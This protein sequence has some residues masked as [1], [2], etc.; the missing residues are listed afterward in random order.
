MKGLTP[1]NNKKVKL[2]AI[3]W[4]IFLVLSC[5][6]K[7]NSNNSTQPIPNEKKK[8]SLFIWSNYVSDEMLQLF[9]KKYNTKVVISN[10][11]SNE[12]L[13]SKLQAGATGYDVIVPS[14]YMV[15]VMIKLNLLQK[16][17]KK[18]IENSK[19]IEDRYLN[20]KFD[21]KN[22]YT[23][24]Y[25]WATSGLA[26]N[27]KYFKGKIKSW[28]NLFEMPELKGK[29]N[30]LDDSREVFGA[31]LKLDGHS[32]NSQNKD[33]LQKAK[34]YLKKHKSQVRSFS[35]DPIELLMSGE[36]W[37]SQMY[38]SDALQAQRKTNG[39]IEYI[40]PEEGCT[41]AIDNLAIPV[42]AKNI[43]GA[44]QLINFLLSQE[45]NLSFV[46]KMFAGPILKT[47]KA[48]LSP[49]MQKND[50]LFPQQKVLQSL[51]M[52]TDIGETTTVIDRLW[53]E[54]KTE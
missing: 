10:Y 16:L 45:N 29:I 15:A 4:L 42:G 34:D 54:L 21:A 24:P 2:I 36:V 44:Q 31:A 5:T 39:D 22:D 28:K 49:E 1:M 46:N 37:A 23:L 30:L 8:V 48:Q 52:M 41:M 47:T 35:S 53:T 9:E 7:N 18:G 27:K 20:L 50:S 26:V 33:D 40:I 3:F 11:S 6:S 17:D 14:D 12:E 32:L 19:N 51:E 43:E 13:L 25:G 38:S